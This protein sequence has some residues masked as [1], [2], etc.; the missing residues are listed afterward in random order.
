MRSVPA[1][2]F[3]RVNSFVNVWF[4]QIII[5]TAFMSISSQANDTSSVAHASVHGLRPHVIQLQVGASVHHHDE[6]LA[7]QRI[8]LASRALQHDYS[9]NKPTNGSFYRW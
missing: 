2:V 1:S 9:G 8:G 6:L 4:R 5:V 7:R 3:G